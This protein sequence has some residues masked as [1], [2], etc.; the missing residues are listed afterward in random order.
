MIIIVYCY[1]G[2]TSNQAGIFQVIPKD[3]KTMTA[4]SRAISKNLLFS[5]LDDNER[6]FARHFFLFVGLKNHRIIFNTLA[7]LQK[8]KKVYCRIPANLQ[9][10]STVEYPRN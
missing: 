6:R 5:H 3:Y 8:I 7:T 9:F 1:V 2:I 4:L 10:S